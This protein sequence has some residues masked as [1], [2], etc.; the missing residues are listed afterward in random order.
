MGQFGNQPDFA[1]NDIKQLNPSD[2]INQGTFLNASIIYIGSAGDMVVIPAGAVG[3]S[4]ITGFVSP[5]FAG[6]RGTGYEDARFNI[7]TTGG[8]GTGLTVNFTAVDGAVQTVAVNTAGTG[9]LNGD[10][11]TIDPQGADPGVGA[12]FRIEA[13]VGTPTGKEGVFFKGLQAGGFLP[14]TVDYVLATKGLPPTQNV[15]TVDFLIAAK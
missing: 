12:T 7:D 4:V 15:T 6:S 11:I 10:L 1:T 2:N 3:E 9:Y 14:V 8:S 5:G 13:T